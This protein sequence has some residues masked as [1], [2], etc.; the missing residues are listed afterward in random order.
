MVVV[1]IVGVLSAI[2]L[3]RVFA[4]I[5]T[6]ATAEASQDAARIASAISAYAQS[7]QKSAAAIK[8]EIDGK[9]VTPD[10]SGANETYILILQIE[11]APDAQFEYSILAM[12]VAQGPARAKLHCALSLREGPMPLLTAA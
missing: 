11:L 9:N 5:R 1:T 8:A 12:V 2:G 7:Q 4:Y 10:L 6:S 3:P